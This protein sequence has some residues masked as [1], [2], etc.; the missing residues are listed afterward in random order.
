MSAE[1]GFAPL[2]LIVVVIVAV[3]KEKTIS[4]TFSQAK[5][6]KHIYY[7]IDVILGCYTWW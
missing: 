5:T 4:A 6:R 3:S 1:Y 2:W 7:L